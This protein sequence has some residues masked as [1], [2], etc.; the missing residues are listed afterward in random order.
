MTRASLI[1]TECG[2]T[3]VALSKRNSNA[4]E[5]ILFL[6]R[7]CAVSRASNVTRVQYLM[8]EPLL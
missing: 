2:F 8:G 3:V 5:I 4:V 1:L 6:H 7:L